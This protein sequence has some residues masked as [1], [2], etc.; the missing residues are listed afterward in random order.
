ME[1]KKFISTV[2]GFR[3]RFTNKPN[4][5]LEKKSIETVVE[6]IGGKLEAIAVLKEND[7]EL[8]SYVRRVLGISKVGSTSTAAKKVSDTPANETVQVSTSKDGKLY[9]IDT[10]KKTCKRVLKDLSELANA[11]IEI[12]E[13]NMTTYLRYLKDKFPGE[14]AQIKKGKLYF[15]GYRISCD[16]ENGF[17]VEDSTKRYA[18]VETEFEGIPTPKELGEFFNR[19]RVEHTP[20]EL[21]A[22]VERGKELAKKAKEESKRNV[23]KE[24]EPIDF[25]LLRLQV[26]GKI[27]GIRE[28]KIVDF[29]PKNF[30]DMIPFRRW[31]RNV[32]I[33][34]KQWKERK[35]RYAKFLSQLETITKEETFVVEEKN[36]RSEFVGTTL[37][38]FKTIG[39]LKG[40]KLEVDGKLV[41][42]VPFLLDYI[43]HYEPKAMQQIM[44]FAQGEV[45]DYFLLKNP[46][47]ND[48]KV[49]FNKRALENTAHHAQVLT[50][51]CES[52]G[53]VAPQDMLY[54]ADLKVG[55][56]ILLAIDGEWKTKTIMQVENGICINKEVG[57]TKLDKWIKLPN[58]DA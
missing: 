37:P 20:E 5:E 3:T 13:M 44:K 33:L 58:K 39:M 18:V 48:W 22:A 30:A 47:L 6:K 7:A 45:T 2:K 8:L 46:F 16:T 34:L 9:E 23:E 55:D 52:L 14:G 11:D 42:A 24:E 10:V 4:V 43:L 36:H 35:I 25:E 15:R 12:P 41:D 29:D 28:K 40:N 53:M 49:E 1:A 57:L 31:K 27:K 56:K 17:M 50:A 21:K 51:L 26:L 54:E 32:G 19:P 38:E